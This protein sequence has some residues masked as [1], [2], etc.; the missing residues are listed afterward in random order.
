M[1]AALSI[2]LI[3]FII[4]ATLFTSFENIILSTEGSEEDNISKWIEWARNAWSYYDPGV[5]VDSDTGILKAT[6]YWPYLT[7]WDLGGYIISI[8]KAELMGILP[9]E[10][11]WGADDRIEKVLKFLETRPISSYGVPYRSYRSA[12]GQPREKAITNVSDAG[13]LLIALNLLKKY[14]PDLAKRINDIVARNGFELLANHTDAW[15][16]TAGFYKYYVAHGFK[17]FGF[18]KAR[19]VQE[20][21]REFEKIKNGP[22][23]NVFGISLPVTEVTT[24]PMLHMV[25]EIGADKDYMDYLQRVYSVQEARY[26]ATNRLTAWSEGNTGLR[27]PPYVYQWI[28][29]PRGDTWK[30]TPKNIDPIVFTKVAFGLHALFNTDYTKLLVDYVLRKELERRSSLQFIFFLPAKGFIEGADES[31]RIVGEL[32]D[33]TQTII[34]EAAYYALKKYALESSDVFI[35]IPSSNASPNET[36]LLNF[37]Y[38][39]PTPLKHN[40]KYSVIIEGTS[41]SYN[42]QYEFDGKCNFS[43]GWQPLHNDNYRVKVRAISDYILFNKTMEKSFMIK[44]GPTYSAPEQVIVN[45]KI[46]SVKWPKWVCLDEDFTLETLVLYNLSEAVT[47]LKVIVRNNLTR[48]IIA[49]SDIVNVNGNGTALFKITI[50]APNKEGD[51]LLILLPAYNNGNEW[52]E[53]VEGATSVEI[54]V[55]SEPAGERV[56]VDREIIHVTVTRS[57]VVKQVSTVTYTVTERLGGEISPTPVVM[58]IMVIVCSACLF[59]IVAATMALRLRRFRGSIERIEQSHG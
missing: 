42:M 17:F 56:I 8:I 53:L 20:A 4:V 36:I 52:I 7:D 54:K 34:I 22:H 27:N 58:L 32:V 26:R 35:D 15:K 59:A 2:S 57:I 25:F 24:E 31:G 33:K 47:P 41:T 13:R 38:I 55:L 23:V 40:C 5:G 37:T 12:D 51:L 6:Y 18:D 45:A 39:D 43:L 9:K 14:R 19:P 3:I 30:I 29:T 16:T 44:V 28:V 50:K 49:E 1:K 11:E 21:L 10:G 48:E 46:V